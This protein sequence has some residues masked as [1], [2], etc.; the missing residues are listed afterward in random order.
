MG[1]RIPKSSI[2]STNKRVLPAGH[3]DLIWYDPSE[4]IV[5]GEESEYV[6]TG[7]IVSAG[8]A[9]LSGS[10]VAGSESPEK[11]EEKE[12]QAKVVE[13]AD[14]PQLSDIEDVQFTKYFDPVSKI[15][16]AKAVIKIRNSSK[17]KDKIAGVDARLYQP[18]GA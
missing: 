6:A 1:K 3:P 10:I 7:S 4:V 13:L 16:K 2:V 18:R 9:I 15:E 8:S 12:E 14:V 17:N 11:E 5:V